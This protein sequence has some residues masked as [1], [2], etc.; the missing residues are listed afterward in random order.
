MNVYCS[1]GTLPTPTA[2]QTPDT[3][4]VPHKPVDPTGGSG[5]NDP[6]Q[7]DPDRSDIITSILALEPIHTRESLDRMGLGPT[8]LRRLQDYL[9][10]ICD[11]DFAVNH[12]PPS[13]Q[14]IALLRN[15]RPEANVPDTMRATSM[16]LESLIV[17]RIKRR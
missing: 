12:S 10:E 9:D 11:P 4:D 2:P 15:M 14:Q 7:G 17:K 6:N 5:K 16:L 8:G 1:Q 13:L 3:K